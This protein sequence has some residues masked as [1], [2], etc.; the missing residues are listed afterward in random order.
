MSTSDLCI[1]PPANAVLTNHV[2]AERLAQTAKQVPRLPTVFRCSDGADRS[3]AGPVHRRM[4]RRVSEGWRSL[5]MDR[6]RRTLDWLQSPADELAALMRQSALLEAEAGSAQ[7]GVYADVAIA[8]YQLRLFA[9][10]RMMDFSDKAAPRSANLLLLLQ[11]IASSY[12]PI[13]TTLTLRTQDSLSV[14]PTLQWSSRPIYLFSRVLVSRETQLTV[15]IHL[16][17]AQSV[18]LSPLTLF[19]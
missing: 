14:E 10:A 16:P 17:D 2:L 6:D 7:Q 15:E 11:P 8:D 9:I 19:S 5:P 3:T 4:R 12:L 13:G 1:A 18:V